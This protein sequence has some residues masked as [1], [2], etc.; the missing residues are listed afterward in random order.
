MVIIAIPQRFQVVNENS[1]IT[2]GLRLLPFA[3]ATPL[4]SGLSSLAAGR[5][6]I[7]P[8]YIL[9]AGAILQTVGYAFLSTIPT[10][11]GVWPGQYGYDVIAALGTGANIAILYLVTPFTVE[12]RDKCRLFCF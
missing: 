6:K 5:L 1:S 11:G 10:S 12:E 8:I 2:A 3:V 4:G 7:P 9:L